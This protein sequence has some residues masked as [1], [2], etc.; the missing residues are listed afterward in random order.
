MSVAG[1]SCWDIFFVVLGAY[2]ILRGLCRGFVGEVIALV[3]FLASFY[4]AFQFSGAFGRFIAGTMGINPYAAQAIAGV[5]I[6]L[7]I[8]MAASVVRMVLRGIIKA[9]SLGGI[10]KLLECTNFDPSVV[11]SRRRIAHPGATESVVMDRHENARYL[12]IVGG[13]YNLTPARATMLK[14]IPLVE[15]HDGALWWSK[16]SFQPAVLNMRLELGADGFRPLPAQE[17]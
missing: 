9:V 10:D 3:G 6:W 13:F 12:G 11:M 2:F 17:K 4:C 7:T 16:R 15:E 1:F 8:A 5:V 14:A